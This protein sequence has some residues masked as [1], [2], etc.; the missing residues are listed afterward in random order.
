MKKRKI[1]TQIPRDV[2]KLLKN[3]HI[4][5]LLNEKI[6]V[7]EDDENIDD[8]TKREIKNKLTIEYRNLLN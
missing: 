2:Q 8:E 5:R 7:I 3:L 4:M 1:H 6:K